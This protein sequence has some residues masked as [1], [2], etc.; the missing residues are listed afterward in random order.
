MNDMKSDMDK[1][2]KEGKTD[3]SR[4]A[5]YG[6]RILRIVALVICLRNLT[7]CF[8]GKNLFPSYSKYNVLMYRKQFWLSFDSHMLRSVAVVLIAAVC[9]Y[10]IASWFVKKKRVVGAY[11]DIAADIAVVVVLVVHLLMLLY[12]SRSYIK[13]ET[14]TILYFACIGLMLL[15]LLIHILVYKKNV[16]GFDRTISKYGKIVLIA[17]SG[18]VIVTAVFFV[19]CGFKDYLSF[20]KNYGIYDQID[21]ERYTE[22]EDRMGNHRNDAVNVDGNIYYAECFFK[23]NDGIMCI[24]DRKEIQLFYELDKEQGEIREIAY[25]QGWIYV[26]IYQFEDDCRIIRINTDTKN[27]ETLVEADYIPCMEVKEHYLYYMSRNNEDPDY[28]YLYDIYRM[29]LTSVVSMDEQELYIG[30]VDGGWASEWLDFYM[31]YMYDYYDYDRV[32]SLELQRYQQYYEDY[33]YV[34]E[35]GNY[36][37]LEQ[38]W[39]IEPK[40]LCISKEEMQV[41]VENVTD[42][43]I[44]QGVL[45]YAKVTDD[46]AVI[47]SAGLDGSDAKVIAGYD[48]V[49]KCSQMIVGENCIVCVLIDRD[50]DRR[51]EIIDR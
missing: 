7:F 49:L 19:I 46:G 43:N 45:Y 2:L 50:A 15:I 12:C 26:N 41:K 21:H 32:S 38:G 1:K 16:A 36:G 30:C 37:G 42:Y 40:D 29:P 47:Y 25:D 22:L 34:L 24:D 51:V 17:I 3:I 27:V 18:A 35:E 4:A 23:G 28:R 10:V 13:P 20:K 33:T 11:L 44:Y 9:F 48:D 14:G 6:L 31:I 5:Y 8:K 39:R